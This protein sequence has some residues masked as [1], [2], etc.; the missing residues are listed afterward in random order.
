MKKT[1]FLVMAALALCFVAAAQKKA[2][3]VKKPVVA[4]NPLKNKM[5]SFSYAVGLA[6][7]SNMKQSNITKVNFAAFNKAMET[8]FS[9]NEPLMSQ[10]LTNMTIQQRMQEYMAEKTKAEKAK[11]AAYLASNK[12][13]AGV[14]TLP[15]GLQYEVLAKSTLPQRVKPKPEDTVVVHYVG[16]L[17][18][19]KEFDNSVKRGQPAQFAVGGVIRGWTEILQLMETGDKWKVTIPSELG[20]GEQGN[21]GIPGGAVLV[22]E[23]DLLEVKQAKPIVDA[24]KEQPKQ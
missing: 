15:N 5:D 22:F 1:T 23:I 9:G 4:A 10:E 6:V 12:S 2:T 24:P 8:I 14:T 16:T 13:K 19:G 20:Y 17:V 21:Q 3:G 11:G 7:A 18:D